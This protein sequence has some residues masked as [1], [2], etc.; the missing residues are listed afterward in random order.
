MRKIKTPNKKSHRTF[1]LN[2]LDKLGMSF[3]IPIFSSSVLSLALAILL[4]V[5]W[6]STGSAQVAPGFV[7]KDR[8]LEVEDLGIQY[9]IGLAFSNK[10]NAFHVLESSKPSQPAQSYTDIVTITAVEDKKG[11]AP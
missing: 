10:A 5:N 4:A 6:S 8:A 3:R 11:W 2:A 1:P 7:R 9:P